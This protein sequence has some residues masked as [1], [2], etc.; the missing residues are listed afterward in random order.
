MSR[1]HTAFEKHVFSFSYSTHWQGK[2]HGKRIGP[3]SLSSIISL[4]SRPDNHLSACCVSPATPRPQETISSGAIPNRPR[5]HSTP[6]ARKDCGELLDLSPVRVCTFCF[7]SHHSWPGVKP[8]YLLLPRCVD[9]T[10]CFTL[11]SG[12]G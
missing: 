1:P 3:N 12:E 11:W 4:N 2:T 5:D 8:S 7:H 10:F 6:F 9:L